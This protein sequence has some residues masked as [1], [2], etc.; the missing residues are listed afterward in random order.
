M[1]DNRDLENTDNSNVADGASESGVWNFSE[2]AISA[3]N[4][5]SEVLDADVIFYNGP[6]DQPYDYLFIE[7]CI[8]RVRRTNI[9]LILVTD[10]GSADSAFRMAAWLQEH[11]ERFTLYVTGH[12]KSAGTLIAMG[13]HVLVISEDH[14]ELG[15][16][17]VQ[18][19]GPGAKLSGL[20]F[21]TALIKLDEE[22]SQ[23]YDVFLSS[24]SEEYGGVVSNDYAMQ[25]ASDIVVGLYGQAY[26]QIDP[27]HI[28][29]A[30]RA[31][32]IASRYGTRLL[33]EGQNSDEERLDELISDYPSHEYVI[34]HVEAARL[35]NNVY[36]TQD[37]YHEYDLGLYLGE[38]AVFPVP[39]EK[40][41]MDGFIPFAFLSTEPDVEDDERQG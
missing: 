35:F 33:E 17:D 13:A 14:G 41:D 20:T 1:T 16:L 6:I 10:G 11:Y 12:C 31:M 21:S 7:A 3:A 38:D 32:D 34:D 26:A 30:S 19:G 37:I 28:G 18:M 23:A 5:V 24:I 9:V 2:D 8:V 15:P 4:A 40:E 39:P 29:Q 27:M 25:I 22:A 36:I